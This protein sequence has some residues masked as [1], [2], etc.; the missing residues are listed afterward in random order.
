MHFHPKIALHCKFLKREQFK[1]IWLI[2]TYMY[3]YRLPNVLNGKCAWTEEMIFTLF[4]LY[5]YTYD[6]RIRFKYM[7]APIFRLEVVSQK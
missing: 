6:L 3:I 2:D 1:K 7:I 4:I 5:V